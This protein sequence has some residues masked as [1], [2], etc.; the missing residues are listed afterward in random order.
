MVGNSKCG[1]SDIRFF[2]YINPNALWFY[3]SHRVSISRKEDDVF[4][5]FASI[6]LTLAFQSFPLQTQK[7]T[8]LY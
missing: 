7:V 4:F 5:V 8:K 1:K 2:I 6:L 3:L